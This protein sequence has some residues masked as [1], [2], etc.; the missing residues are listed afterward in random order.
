[1][2]PATKEWK[3]LDTSAAIQWSRP[4]H[5]KPPFWTRLFVGVGVQV[6]EELV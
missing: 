1:M 2:S 4:P 6:G 3:V 5:S